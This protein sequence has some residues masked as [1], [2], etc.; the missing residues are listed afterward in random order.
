MSKIARHSKCSVKSSTSSD[1]LVSFAASTAEVSEQFQRSTEA[2]FY[3]L[4]EKGDDEVSAL[5][6]LVYIERSHN[7][8]QS[9]SCHSTEWPAR[10]IED[11]LPDR[12]LRTKR[13]VFRSLKYSSYDS[14]ALRLEDQDALPHP[15][16]RNNRVLVSEPPPPYG[17]HMPPQGAVTEM[18]EYPRVEQPFQKNGG[19]GREGC[20]EKALHTA[21]KLRFNPFTHC[22]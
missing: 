17:L 20:W 1:T 15:S 5:D 4:G 9:N 6:Q 16:H 10:A 14:K 12:S 22:R 11:V 21:S 2:S 7:R 3:D 18:S 8:A 13:R 19:H